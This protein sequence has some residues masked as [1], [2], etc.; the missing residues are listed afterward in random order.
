MWHRK[1]TESLLYYMPEDSQW[2]KAGGTGGNAVTQANTL[3]I[4]F[5]IGDLVFELR[6]SRH[7]VFQ[8]KTLHFNSKKCR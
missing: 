2:Y 8:D 5:Q 7:L 1:R 3:K 4:H 6:Y